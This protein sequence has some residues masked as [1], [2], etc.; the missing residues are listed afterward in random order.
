MMVASNMADHHDHLTK[1]GDVAV[2]SAKEI[3]TTAPSGAEGVLRLQAAAGNQSV[4]HFLDAAQAKLVVG[5]VDDPFEHEA[6]RVAD[7]VVRSLRAPSIVA[8]DHLSRL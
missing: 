6:D 8:G 7:E 3:A 2:H 4:I 1:S 5:A